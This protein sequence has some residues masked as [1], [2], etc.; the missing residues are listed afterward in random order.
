MSGLC[1]CLGLVLGHQDEQAWG[2]GGCSLWHKLGGWWADVVW[3]A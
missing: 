2:V 1:R 3:L